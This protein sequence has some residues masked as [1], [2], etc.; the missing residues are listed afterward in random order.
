MMQLIPKYQPKL[1]VY[2]D[3]CAGADFVHLF[4]C[5]TDFLKEHGKAMK[6]FRLR[7]VEKTK[8]ELHVATLLSQYK[9]AIG[10]TIEATQAAKSQQSKQS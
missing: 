7:E 2:H 10:H 4:Y 1:Q 8:V 9:K 5:A 6:A 3:R